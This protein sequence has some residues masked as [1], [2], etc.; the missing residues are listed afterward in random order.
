MGPRNLNNLVGIIFR[1]RV[2][3]YAINADVKEHFNQ[4]SIPPEQRPLVAFL[5][6]KD[7][8][9]EPDVYVN[10]RHIFGV[11][12]SPAVAILALNESCQEG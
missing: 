7:P 11:A 5:W 2:G 4:V 1:F 9:E 12:C 3:K 8:N 6:H 10:C